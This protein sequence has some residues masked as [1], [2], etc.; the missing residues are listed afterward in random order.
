[1]RG[2]GYVSDV[3]AVFLIRSGKPTGFYVMDTRDTDR[4][5]SNLVTSVQ[6]TDN[7]IDLSP[8]DNV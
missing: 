3:L 1:M 6:A 8:A 5:W 2:R 7:L 4:A